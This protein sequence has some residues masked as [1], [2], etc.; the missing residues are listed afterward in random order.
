MMR[1]AIPVFSLLALSGCFNFQETYNNAARSDCRDAVNADERRACLDS[2][3]RN[4][5]E[6]RAEQRS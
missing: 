5:S 4:A 3:E 6:K 2:V 1:I